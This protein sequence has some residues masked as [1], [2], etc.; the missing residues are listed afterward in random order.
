[1]LKE[2]NANKSSIMRGDIF[3]KGEWNKASDS[4]TKKISDRWSKMQGEW[5]RKKS[6]I[7][8]EIITIGQITQ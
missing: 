8:K 6:L 4:V 7:F 5:R 1:M 2:N 3:Q